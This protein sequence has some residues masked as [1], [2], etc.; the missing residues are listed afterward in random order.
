M[1]LASFT[2]ELV[3]VGQPGLAKTAGILGSVMRPTKGRL[4]ERMIAAGALS[5]GAGHAAMKAKAGMTGEYGPE[6]T[7]TSALSKGAIGGLLASLGLKALGKM[8]KTRV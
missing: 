1:F 8:S 5:G 4:T 2:D 3:R 6:G 7:S